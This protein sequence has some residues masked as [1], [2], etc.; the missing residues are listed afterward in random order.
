MREQLGGQLV[1]S[2][3]QP[4]TG[5][6]N[7]FSHHTPNLSHTPQAGAP[8]ISIRD[9][10]FLCYYPCATPGVR[11]KAHF[12]EVPPLSGDAGDRLRN[13]GWLALTKDQRHRLGPDLLS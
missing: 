13:G 2:Q 11:S 10:L 6:K 1:A 4:T 3:S 8:N 5:I 7:I 9:S 12:S